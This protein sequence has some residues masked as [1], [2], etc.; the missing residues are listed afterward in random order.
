MNIQTFYEYIF[1]RDILGFLVPGGILMS[2]FWILIYSINQDFWNHFQN[3]FSDF[4]QVIFALF[5]LAV[6]FVFGHVIDFLYRN[7]LQSRKIY[8]HQDTIKKI[9]TLADGKSK[10]NIAKS[11]GKFMKVEWDELTIDEWVKSESSDANLVLRY[12]IEQKNSQLFRTEIAR[13]AI[14]AHFLTSTGIS[15]AFFSICILF[16]FLLQIIGIQLSIALDLTLTIFVL[17]SLAIISI[18]LVLQGSHKREILIKHTYHVFHILWKEE[19][20][21][22][23]K[24]DKKKNS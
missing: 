7:L 24:Q 16:T 23:K 8:R 21:K 6:A 5:G 14:Q 20:P 15:V 1:L 12:W 4:N 18:I 9:I 22:N 10:N 3:P 11:V 13:P 17:I 2:G 19:K